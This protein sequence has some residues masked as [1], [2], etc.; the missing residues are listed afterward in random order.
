MIGEW[1]LAGA[2]ANDTG[3]IYLCFQAIPKA[4]LLILCI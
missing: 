1:L 2:S 4:A 3:G